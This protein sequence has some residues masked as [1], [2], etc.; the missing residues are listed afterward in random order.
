MP[1]AANITE[2]CAGVDCDETMMFELAPVSL[3]LEDY[4]EV[5]TLFEA[6]DRDGIRDLRV[7]FSQNPSQAKS[8]AEK[9]RILRV[10][11]RTLNLFGVDDLP[12]LV[13]NLG[14]I[15]RDEMLMNLVEELIQLWENKGGFVSNGVNYSLS[16]QRLDVQINGT[17]LPG[18][19]HNWGRVLV[20][21]EDV[22]EREEARR[23][24]DRSENYSRG[25]FEHSPISLWVEDFSK[26]RLLL[27]ELRDRGIEDFRVF[28]DVHPDFVKRCMAEIRVIDINKHTLKL[29]A[30]PD[31]KTLLERLRDIFRDDMTLAFREQLIDLWNGKLFQQREVVNYSLDGSMLHLHL[32]FTV[33]PGCEDDWS[34]VQ[35]ALTDISA[36]RKAEAYLEYLGQH[37]VLTKLHNRT[38]FVDELNRLERVGPLPVTVVVIDVNGLKEVNDEFGHA[39]G[40]E[41][42]R[43]AGEVLGK[44]VTEPCKVARIGGDEFAVL[45]PARERRDGEALIEAIGNLVELNNQYYSGAPLGMSMGLAT[46]LIGERLESVVGRADAAMFERKRASYSEMNYELRGRGASSARASLVRSLSSQSE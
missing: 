13:L 28:T 44:A 34:M 42:L 38:F 41:L 30:A 40:D 39:A 6:L 19:E 5:R 33:F 8:C 1:V 36:R 20:A 24:L 12:H 26:I 25:L 21:V 29:F 9:I 43:R 2:A 31:R 15:F 23:A 18:Y 46:S 17:V 4:S 45:M 14:R 22:T 32:Q 35:V 3:W 10:N 37:D 27:Q 11:R 16:G 7:Y